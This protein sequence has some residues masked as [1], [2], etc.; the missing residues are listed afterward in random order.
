MRRWRAHAET[1]KAAFAASN[2]TLPRAQMGGKRSLALAVGLIFA[3]GYW[4]EA[5]SDAVGPGDLVLCVNVAPNHGTVRPCEPERPIVS[6]RS[7][8]LP[9]HADVPMLCWM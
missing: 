8:N 5:M 1:A 4:M 6:S 7:W 9:A 3:S 2:R